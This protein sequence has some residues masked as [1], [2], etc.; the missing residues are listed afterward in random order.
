MSLMASFQTSEAFTVQEPKY[1]HIYTYAHTHIHT[2]A[3]KH[4]SAASER[5]YLL[6]SRDIFLCISIDQSLFFSF[7]P[8]IDLSLNKHLSVCI[9]VNLSI[10]LFLPPSVYQSIYLCECLSVCLFNLKDFKKR[11]SNFSVSGNISYKHLK[12]R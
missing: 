5:F 11:R 7:C 1:T 3:H 2:H 4:K 12:N 9:C 10:Y 6:M 8:L